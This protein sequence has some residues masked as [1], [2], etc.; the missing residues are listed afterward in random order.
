MGEGGDLC[1]C[2]SNGE[3]VAE[4]SGFREEEIRIEG[5]RE[6]E[7][8]IEKGEICV[9]VGRMEKGEKRGPAPQTQRRREKDRE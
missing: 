5:L 3:G 2:G 4:R 8:R 1:V 6:E 7:R 9:C